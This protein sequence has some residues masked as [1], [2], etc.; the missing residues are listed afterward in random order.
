[1]MGSTKNSFNK[2]V[3]FGKCVRLNYTFIYV[4]RQGSS[5]L[6]LI[7]IKTSCLKMEV[8]TIRNTNSNCGE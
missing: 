4:L 6:S 2:R 7:R 8:E 3:T 1:M 5:Q